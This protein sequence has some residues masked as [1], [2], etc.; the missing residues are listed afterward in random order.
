MSATGGDESLLDRTVVADERD[1]G[2]VVVVVDVRVQHTRARP[3]K[4]LGDC[5]DRR[6]IPSLRDVRNGLEPGHGA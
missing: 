4:R 2:A 3:G 6:R 5:G 1:D